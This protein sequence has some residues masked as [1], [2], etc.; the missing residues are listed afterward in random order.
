VERQAQGHT[1]LLLRFRDLLIAGRRRRC[2]RG[3]Q[4]VAVIV[5]LPRTVSPS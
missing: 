1:F 5:P 4:E 2:C 3:D